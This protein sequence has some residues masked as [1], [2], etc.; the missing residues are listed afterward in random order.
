MNAKREAYVGHWRIVSMENW[1][2]EYVDMEVEAYLLVRGDLTGEFQFGLVQGHL[3]GRLSR[4]RGSP[5][6]RF[7]W[8]GFDENDP[9]SGRGW[10][11]A[12]GDTAAGRIEFDL[13]DASKF[14]TRRQ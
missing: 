7:T 5:R 9:V 13:G 1:D 10:F 6:L 3:A 11:A 4:S 2:A 12:D 8:S 14:I